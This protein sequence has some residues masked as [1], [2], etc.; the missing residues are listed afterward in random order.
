MQ[1]AGHISA[2]QD[3]GTRFDRGLHLACERSAEISAREGSDVS[4]GVFGITGLQSLHG[5][6]DEPSELSGNGLFDDKPLGRNAALSRVQESR[7]DGVRCDALEV[8]VGQ[9]DEWVRTTEFKDTLL[10][11]PA[12]NCRHGASGTFTTRQGHGGDSGVRDQL[13]C[14]RG[15]IVLSDDECGEN[16]GRQA[17][18]QQ[19]ALYR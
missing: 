17:G 10:D 2:G 9:H 11:R 18:L 7:P 4:V 14:R 19:Y 3:N 5:L 16:A 1:P 15:H 8:G 13:L 12:R 6:N